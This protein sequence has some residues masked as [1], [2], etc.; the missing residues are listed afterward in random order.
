MSKTYSGLLEDEIAE[1]LRSLPGDHS[2]TT[3]Y[4]SYYPARMICEDGIYTS[5]AGRYTEYLQSRYTGN[6]ISRTGLINRLAG[7]TFTVR[8]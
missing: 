5:G 6:H 7:C 4:H 8:T 1:L 2:I 3:A